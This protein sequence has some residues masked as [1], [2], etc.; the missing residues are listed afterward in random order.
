MNIADFDDVNHWRTLVVID[1]EN[2]AILVIDSNGPLTLAV[3]VQFLVVHALKIPQIPLI[4]RGI[5][6]DKAATR[7]ANDSNREAK[8]VGLISADATEP[9]V[10]EDYPHE[11]P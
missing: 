6:L 3:S 7:S 8:L 1:S 5:Q 9:L 2:D 11:K 10:I 4:P